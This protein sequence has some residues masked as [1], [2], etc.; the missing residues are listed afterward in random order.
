MNTPVDRMRRGLILSA[1]TAPLVAHAS[2]WPSKPIRLVV[3]Y[4]AGGSTD[5]LARAIEKSL[6]EQLGQPIV[7]DNKPGAGGAIG[8]ELVA[9][10]PADGYT[11]VF[12]NSAPSGLVSLLRKV[13]Y[14]VTADFQPIST[15]AFVPLALVGSASLPVRDFRD[16]LAYARAKEKGLNYGSVGT[17]SMAHLTGEYFNE[18]SGARMVHVP[19]TGG[20]A[21]SLA[22]ASGEVETGWFNP[23]DATAL[24]ASGKARYLAV[25][26]AQRF[27]ALPDV[28][29]VAELFPGFES[30]AWFG[31]LAPKGTPQDIVMRLNQAIAN[32]L[33]RPDVRKVIEDKMA[34]PRGTTPQEMAGIMKAELD[35]WGPIIS[36][37]NIQL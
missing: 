24:V 25:A 33:K 27:P 7:I 20:G 15:V 22:V 12:G 36:K 26:T 28:P 35:H 1:C 30:A 14:N 13:P 19:Y 23:L 6:T 3:P 37:N 11:L 31:V 29:T 2:T 10:A 16:F 21:L 17:G 5:Q 9:R 4:S 18:V 8:T 34:Q 32:A